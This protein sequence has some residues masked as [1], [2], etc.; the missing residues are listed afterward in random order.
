MTKTSI[1]LLRYLFVATWL[2]AGCLTPAWAQ[3][4][5]ITGTIKLGTDNSPIP[6]VNVLI[7][8]STVGTTSD[9]NGRY[10]LEVS[11]SSP[12]LVYSYIG[13]K[14]EEVQI[15]NRNTIDVTMTESAETLQEAVVTAL[16][17]KRE[18]RSL[19]Y[20]VGKID[21]KDLTR[22]VQENVLNSMAGKVA[23]VTISATGGTGS[24]V[25]MVI[26]GAKSLSSD[27][28]PLFVVDGV[29]IA[30]TLNNVS[31]VGNDNR[32]DYGNAISGLN[33]D[34][35][36]TISILKGPSA[37]ALYGTRAGNG[38]VLI[39]TKS[40]SKVKK[41]T[42]TI[43]S[44]TVFDKPYKFLK[45][46]TSFGSGQYSAIPVSI[47]KNP[48][49]NPFGKLIEEQIGATYGAALDKGYEEVQWN[50]PLDAN[51]KPIPMPL[52][53][54]PNNV[55]NFVQTG[56]TTTNGISV[57]NSN[58]QITY[59]ISYS[60]MQNHGIIPNSD[61]FKNT[62]NLSTSMKLNNQLRLSTN[63][64]ISRNSSNNRPAGNRGSNPLQAAYNTSPHIDLRD[65]K[66]YWM[67]GQVGLQQRTQYNGIY[68][69][70]YFLANEVNNGFTRDRLF[71]NMKLDWQI[72]KDLS[73]MG[74]YALDTYTEERET[75]IANSYTND[76]RGA[77]GVINLKPFENNI[78]FLASYKKEVS[79][80][81]ISFSVGGN[82]RYQKGSNVTT[83]TRGGT[84]LI[85]P[86]VFTIQNISPA[87]LD[88]NSTRYERGIYSLYGLA[89]LSFKDMV[90][91]DLTARNDWSSTLP[92]ANRSYFYPSAS[93]SVLLNEI[94][95]VSSSISLLK[96]RGGIAQVGNDANPYMLLSTLDNAGSWD[97]IPRLNVPGTLLISNLKPEIATSKEVGLDVSLFR[98][99]LRASATYY[100]SENRNQILSTKTPPSS[101]YSLKNIN[102]GLLVSKGYE[103]TLGGTP[104]EKNGWRLDVNANLTRNRTTI[105]KLS[106]DLPYFTLWTDAKGGAWTYVGDEI[107]DLYDAKV[108]TVED[109]NSP[110]YGY[111]I[112]DQTGKWQAIDAINTRNKIGN[113]NPRFILGMQT[114]LTYRGFSLNMTFD[115][116]NGGDFVSQTYRYGEEDG[117]SQ[118]FLDK[119]INPNGLTGDALRNYLVANQDK[120][121]LMN[122]NNFPLVGGPTP[123]YGGYPFKYGPYTLPHG[124]VFIPGVLA[125]G[126]DE[127]GKPTGY[128]ENL[129]GPGTLMLP[130]AG[131][132]SWAF[133]R[134]VMFDAS[135]LK[136]REVSLG[137]ELPQGF[138]KRLGLQNANVSVYSRNIILWTAAK[139][140][141]DPEMAFQLESGVQS[142]GIQFKQGIERYN[143][144]PWVIPVGFRLG[145]TF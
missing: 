7:K 10:S 89:N 51:G 66:D 123:D 126:Y 135:F 96:L 115:W 138:V 119:L 88:Y 2:L 64:D 4:R 98:N 140:G 23:G 90:Y 120:M 37:A 49:T 72:T 144:T 139:I 21:G 9:I 36:E 82:Y 93:L 77:Y 79:H 62:L 42:V 5:R 141:I 6:G 145:L 20:S 84:G 57:A 16:G 30:N 18:E 65:L 111:P 47:S 136:L 142:S 34:D 44:N 54:H 48:L 127:T 125:T 109:K 128:K 97:G 95:P 137:Y 78:D 3:S 69:N 59:R 68:N 38:V 43:T 32:V 129:G 101:G 26:R 60:N 40:G 116:R 106:D 35:I 130:F 58:D 133:S 8:G 132:T 24:S 108:V 74:R 61:L 41:L 113:F 102:A 13:Y 104:I 12:A 70:P 94:L 39:T 81:G 92:A 14:T 22:V 11:G 1:V 83:A 103:F 143:V 55:K 29:P 45:W 86:G 117:R 17:I 27:N 19:G 73:F 75:K 87:N 31:Q 50:S 15:G 25:S 112:L 56:I 91:L 46:Q 71:G 134:A 33:P 121:I 53:S 76:P 110:Y 100:V 28:Q 63:L 105:K 124:G 80:F 122:G 118:L 85:V 99:R 107:G 114:S 131:A 67:P 52:V